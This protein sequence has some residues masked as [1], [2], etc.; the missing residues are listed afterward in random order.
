MKKYLLSLSIILL[1]QSCSIDNTAPSELEMDLTHL[2]LDQQSFLAVVNNITDYPNFSSKKSSIVDGNSTI[3]E[4]DLEEILNPLI[5]NGEVIHSEMRAIIYTSEVYNELSVP[6]RDALHAEIDELSDDQ[7]AELS[8][9]FNISY[10]IDQDVNSEIDWDRL[11]SCASAA[12]G[13]SSI[14]AIIQNNLGAA[15]IETMI[16]ALKHVGKRYLG[17]IGVGLMVYEFINCVYE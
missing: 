11:I 3:P 8:F 15:T 12:V 2:I 1:L 10:Y 7:L 17:W 9:V 16:G 6:E 13:I 14:Q 4:S 5:E